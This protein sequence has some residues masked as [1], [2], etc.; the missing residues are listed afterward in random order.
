[1]A[2]LALPTMETSIE[3]EKFLLPVEFHDFWLSGL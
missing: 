2:E 1:M 3:G